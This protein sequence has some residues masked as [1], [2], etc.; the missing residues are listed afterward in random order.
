VL[1]TMRADFLGKCAA[2]PR[3]AAALSDHQELVGPLTEDEV[4]RAI[5]RPAQL[6]GCELEPGLTD[7]L[8][9]DVEGQ[10]GALPLLQYTLLELWTQRQ[11][12]RLTIAAYRAIGGV[13]G[14]LER[15]AN[16]VLDGFSAAEREICRR[17]FLRLTQPGEGT[18]DTKRR[19]P[20]RELL[21]AEDDTQ[22]IEEVIRRLA[23]ARLITTEGR[24]Q[25]PRGGDGRDQDGY[26]EVAHEALIRGWTQLRRWI[27]ADRAGL[28]V[29]RRLTEA[30]REW[31]DH[32]DDVS[33]LYQG[34]R[35]AV[36][37]EWTEAHPRELNP[38]EREFLQAS[39][40]Y[41]QQRQAD[42][43][44][45]ARRLAEE[46]EARR[47]AEE[48]RARVAELREREQAESARRLR[49]RAWI[50]LAISAT[51]VLI[52]IIAVYEWGEADKQTR[53]AQT[54]EGVAKTQAENAKKEKERAE[55]QA[56]IARSRQLAAASTAELGQHYDL[57]LLLSVAAFR[58]GDPAD[59]A[60][61]ARRSILTALNAKPEL[62]TYLYY[63]E[64]P[65]ASVAFSP[66]GK[67]LA[68]GYGGIS[69]GGVI[70]FDVAT[71]G[72]LGAPLPVREG[73]V[74]SVAFSPDGKSLAAGYGN[75]DDGGVILFDVAGHGRPG[76]PLPV[77]EGR[78]QSVAFSP[79]G[80]SLAAGYVAVVDGG[81]ILFDVAAHGR[82]GTPL[83]VPEGRVRSV[84]YSPDGRSL[85]AG[86]GGGGVGG[87]VGGVILFDVAAPRRLGEPLLVREGSVRSVAFSPDGTTLAAGYAG[88]VGGNAVILF[89]VTSRDRL[90]EQP[91][92]V[93]EGDV[94]GVAFSPDGGVLAAGYGGGGVGGGVVLYDVATHGRLGTPL[95]VREGGVRSIAFSPDGTALAAG[96]GVDLGVGGGV[97]LYD[98]TARG[99]LGTPLPVREGRVWSVAFRPDGADLAAGFG[100]VGGGGVILF[101]VTARG[102]LGTPLP[103][104]E[105]NVRSVAF[106][107]D[108]RTLAAVY[109]VG[110]GFGDGGDG[111]ILYDVASRGRLG[112]PLPVQEGDVR[113]VVFRP[114]G[115]DLAAGYV[116]NVILSDVS[117]R[118]Q[119]G[120][121]LPVDEGQVWSVA[122]SPDGT[123]LAA[124][125]VGWVEGGGVILFDVTARR[126]LGTPLPVPEGKVRSVAFS[127]DGRTLAVGYV[128]GDVGV[129]S[130]GVIVYD[131]AARGR[132]GT[133]LPVQE[134][135][136]Q[137]VAFSPDGKS[138]AVG[139]VVVVDDGVTGGGLILYDATSRGRLGAPL[140]VREGGVRSVAFSPDGKSL[141]A[142]YDGVA[143]GGGVILYDVDPGSWQRLAC[144]IAN[145][146]LSREEW[147]QF[148]GPDVPYQ[149]ICRDLPNGKGVDESPRRDAGGDRRV[150][151]PERTDADRD[152]P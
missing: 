112:T 57:A 105:G 52:S 81:V 48:D 20:N 148:I 90:G 49:R 17:V 53:N 51:T 86:Y 116:R 93:R 47:R 2:Y 39:L 136:V 94:Q 41:Q 79:D 78:V 6:V 96:F 54:A 135:G 83:P 134:G 131:V 60:L 120:E 76:T 152:G 89:D 70:L 129:I 85:A 111:V 71:H 45:A 151:R 23:D 137:S 143:G 66:D 1:L 106:R 7:L 18:E 21:A 33:L 37:R 73:G 108:G 121:R 26:V 146:N 133:L 43:V 117:A 5:E 140:P 22:A 9:Q 100:G 36:A 15:R 32:P 144:R 101:D 28:R 142:G 126:R 31:K 88:V 84:A 69:D 139:Y 138:L 77:P 16:A 55:R 50:L 42:E 125:Y 149:R 59:D 107:P 67:S 123:G 72:R 103:V 104:P 110:D 127:P 11:G 62:L 56:R 4:R 58:L 132:L 38:W 145:R 34:S 95:P 130:G 115:R 99:R 61:E 150:D 25:P 98:V 92:P 8:L 128:V 91:L 12:R 27:E 87:G 97:T 75:V 122:F 65:I 63:D 40:R 24:E 119:P 64:A 10:A 141:A 29:H 14:A 82:L 109:G 102:R 68:A 113:S 147:G 44:A 19:A 118:D 35:L 3:M 13:Q 124:G 46:A 80:K 30:A 114:D 74:R